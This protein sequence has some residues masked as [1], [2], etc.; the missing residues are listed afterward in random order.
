MERW[1][2]GVCKDDGLEIEVVWEVGGG[3]LGMMLGS[4]LGLV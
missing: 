4:K 1:E 2:E 3:T